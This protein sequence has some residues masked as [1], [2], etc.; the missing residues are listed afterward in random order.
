MQPGDGES[1]NH[2]AAVGEVSGGARIDGFF[3]LTTAGLAAFGFV[4]FLSASLGLLAQDGA[5]F[6]MIALKQSIGLV[7][8][9]GLF[10]LFSRF[11]YTYLR[12]IALFIL[13][14]AVAVNLLLFIPALTLHYN[15]ASRWLYSPSR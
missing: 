10:Y 6:G 4:I 5:S 8:G 7:G 1:Q 12:R 11:K 9:A 15:G 2:F 14:G 13:I 3:L